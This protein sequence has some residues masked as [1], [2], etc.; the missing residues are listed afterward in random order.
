MANSEE[1]WSAKVIKETVQEMQQ[2]LASG[3]DTLE[4]SFGNFKSRYP[5]L[6]AKAA[7]K[8]TKTDWDILGKMLEQLQAI[9]DKEIEHYDSSVSVGQDLVD[10]FVKP[11]LPPRTD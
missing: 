11:K 4:S 8:M 10:R 6:Y 9:E 1:N 5:G 3:L 7:K 2:A